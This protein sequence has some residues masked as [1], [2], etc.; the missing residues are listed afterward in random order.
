[1]L[2]KLIEKSPDAILTEMIHPNFQLDKFFNDKRMQERYDWIVLMT[3][4][5]EKVTKCMESNERII[6]IFEKLPNTIYLEGVYEAVRQTNS[7]TKQPN[8]D[9]ISS[10]LHVSNTLLAMMPY[11]ADVLIKIIERIELQ[12]T[13]Y[14]SESYVRL[15]V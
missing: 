6:V 14:K 7:N 5:L 3:K 15:L 10:F 8:F 2:T 11:S 1:M 4:L 13:K 9:L 12:F